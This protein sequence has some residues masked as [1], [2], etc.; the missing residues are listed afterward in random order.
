MEHKPYSLD[1]VTVRYKLARFMGRFKT[2]GIKLC[3]IH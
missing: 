2:V 3:T 1:C